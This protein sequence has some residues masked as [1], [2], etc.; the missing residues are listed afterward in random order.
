MSPCAELPQAGLMFCD[1][2]S[3]GLR[4]DRWTHEVAAHGGGNSEFQIYTAHPRNSRVKNGTLHITPSFTYHQFGD[5]R[6]DLDLYPLG[7]TT[8]WNRGCRNQGSLHSESGNAGGKYWASQDLRK[9]D[10]PAL[11]QTLSDAGLPACDEKRGVCNHMVP[12]GGLRKTPVMSAPPLLAT[13]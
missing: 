3:G 8:D 2:F 1:D 13:H 5:L 9:E 11:R 7:C 10:M 6:G 12:V 4:H